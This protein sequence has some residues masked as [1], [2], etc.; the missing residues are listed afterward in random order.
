MADKTLKDMMPTMQEYINVFYAIREAC[1]SWDDIA[2]Y[3]EN[4][5]CQ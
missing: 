5:E 4:N 1:P 3:W 2:E